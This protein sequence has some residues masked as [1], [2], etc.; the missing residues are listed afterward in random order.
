MA[1]L[2]IL[3]ILSGCVRLPWQKAAPSPEPV[4][5][6]P[7]ITMPVSKGPNPHKGQYLLAHADEARK[8]ARTCTQCHEQAFCDTCH[9]LHTK[10]PLNWL[11]QHGK[12]S[13]AKDA[14]CASCHPLPSCEHCHTQGLPPTH[15]AKFL[16]AHGQREEYQTCRQC[17][18]TES[19]ATC[20]LG[21]QPA[22][23]Q[24]EAWKKGH[25]GNALKAV[26]KCL[27]LSL[28]HI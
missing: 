21:R 25:G 17:H 8:D 10:H 28:I 7:Q 14:T 15:N 22:D 27:G 24:T 2:A 20:H 23:H 6:L 9:S 12:A 13:A 5:A 26:G 18:T 19:C 3:V 11:A 4:Q 1:A 16:T